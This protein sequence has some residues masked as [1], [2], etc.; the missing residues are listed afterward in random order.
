MPHAS[1]RL[2]EPELALLPGYVAALERRWTP[3]SDHDPAGADRLLAAIKRDG[4]G[5]I[6]ALSNPQGLGEPIVL[7]DGSA[8]PRLPWRR[9][10]I[11]DDA[12]GYAGELNLRWQRGTSELPP[13]C[14]GHVGYAVPP[15]HRGAGLAAAA[16]R[17]LTPIARAQGLAWLDIA[18]ATD[19]LASIR[20][21]ENAGA[22]CVHQFNAGAE[23]GD[24]E[25]WLYRLELDSPSSAF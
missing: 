18:M 15:W 5:F 3:E 2:V 20:S 8:V 11:L 9:F 21:A 12:G 24:A 6:S 4:A 17:E 25:A 10:W 14:L 7:A 16:L 13:Y 1:R 19:N 23:H 22:R